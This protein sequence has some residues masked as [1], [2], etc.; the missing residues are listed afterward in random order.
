MNLH[1][2]SL[3]LLSIAC[4]NQTTEPI[5]Y[6]YRLSHELEISTTDLD[7]LYIDHYNT[8]QKI[9]EKKAL[10]FEDLET[11]INKKFSVEGIISILKHTETSLTLTSRQIIDLDLLG[12]EI[13]LLIYLLGSIS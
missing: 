12:V 8:Y 6:S 7:S 13:N 10:N 1:Y 5:S 9:N 4:Q 2:L 3:T 11:L